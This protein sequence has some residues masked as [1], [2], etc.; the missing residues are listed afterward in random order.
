MS[1]GNSVADYKVKIELCPKCDG[2]KKLWFRN[3]AQLRDYL[4]EHDC[5]ISEIR[6]LIRDM[7]VD[8]P[9]CSGVGRIEIWY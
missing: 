1:T 6:Q 9:R 2:M 8:C 3:D 5:T 4:W 7:E